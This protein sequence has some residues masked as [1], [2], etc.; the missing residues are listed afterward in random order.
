MKRDSKKIGTK[1]IL[2]NI[3]FGAFLIKARGIKINK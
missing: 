2:K 1:K 3:F